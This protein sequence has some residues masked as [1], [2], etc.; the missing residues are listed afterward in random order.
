V[1]P[2]RRNLLL[3]AGVAPAALAASAAAAQGSDVAVLERL[4]ALERRLEAAYAAAARR[5]VLGEQLALSLRDQER[6]HARG[7]ELALADH[8]L[9]EPGVP[10]PDPRLDAALRGR[11]AFARYAL[12][13]EGRVVRAYIH[14]QARLRDTGLLRPLGAIMASDAQHAVALRQWLGEPLLEV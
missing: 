14:A 12:G 6:E 7:L 2:T 3:A 4:L 5:D 1:S 13:L 10:R 11:A 8:G 9:A